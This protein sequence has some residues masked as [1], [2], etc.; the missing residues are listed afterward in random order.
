M[1]HHL[2]PSPQMVSAEVEPEGQ[3]ATTEGK[4]SLN[5]VSEVSMTFWPLDSALPCPYRVF[6]P[7]VVLMGF[8]KLLLK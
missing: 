4:L 2:L 5:T 3:E 8:P 6:R 7:L 1:A